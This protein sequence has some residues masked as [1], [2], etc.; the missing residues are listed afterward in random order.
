MKGPSRAERRIL[1]ALLSDATNLSLYVLA[2]TA[3]VWAPL[4]TRL[5]DRLEDNGYVTGRWEDGPAPRRRF[6][7]L[8]EPGRSWAH[9]QLGLDRRTEA[10]NP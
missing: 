1:V 3:Q 8:T 4:V 7:R 5:L 10:A 9:E 2:R 6:Y